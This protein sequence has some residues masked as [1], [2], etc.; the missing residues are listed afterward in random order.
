MFDPDHARHTASTAHHDDR[1]Q[2]LVTGDET[3]LVELQA[4]LSLL[5]LCARGRVFVEV[6]EPSDVFELA[7]PMRMTVAWLPRSTRA[8]RPG[9]AE[10]CR[11]G[12]AVSRAVRAWAAEMLCEG[13]GATK[14]VLTGD[15][16]GVAAV[17][18]DLT[19]EAGMAA[20]AIS[21]PERFRL[22]SL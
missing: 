13:P 9:T 21:S 18:D 10:P 17:F 1:V 19:R 12:D 15:Y 2:F 6:P 20:E 3:S 8:G 4:Q 11:R 16:R 22:Q 5:P 7:V 14:A